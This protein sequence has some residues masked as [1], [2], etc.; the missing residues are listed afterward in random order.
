MFQLLFDCG[1]L[2]QCRL[3]PHPL[4]GEIFRERNQKPQPILRILQFCMADE[5]APIQ[6]RVRQQYPRE[7]FRQPDFEILL[8]ECLENDCRRVGLTSTQVSKPWIARMRVPRTCPSART[9]TA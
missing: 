5:P 4:G 8:Y 3:G 6:I 7:R 2:S 9:P 1:Q